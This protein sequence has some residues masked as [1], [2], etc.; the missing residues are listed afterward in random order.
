MHDHEPWS[1][2]VGIPHFGGAYKFQTAIVPKEGC[3]AAVHKYQAR[4][5]VQRVE[6]PNWLKRRAYKARQ[7][8]SLTPVCIQ[9]QDGADLNDQLDA[10]M[11]RGCA[12]TLQPVLI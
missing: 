6:M 2:K 1:G 8:T 5:R 12:F 9:V 11:P 4:H 10:G 7:A 3:Q